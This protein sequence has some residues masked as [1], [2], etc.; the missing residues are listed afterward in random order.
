MTLS[1]L[2]KHFSKIKP[3]VLTVIFNHNPNCSQLPCINNT[4]STLKK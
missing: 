1:L 2:K 4:N 3:T